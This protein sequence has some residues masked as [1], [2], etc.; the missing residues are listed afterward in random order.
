MASLPSLGRIGSSEDK[1]LARRGGKNKRKSRTRRVNDLHDSR[2]TS[3]NVETGASSSRS[4]ESNTSSSNSGSEDFLV[5]RVGT[6]T[7]KEPETSDFSGNGNVI[8]PSTVAPQKRKS[9]FG[10]GKVSASVGDGIFTES[11]RSSQYLPDFRQV[12][13]SHEDGVGRSTRYKSFIDDKKD[14][15]EAFSMK[16]LRQQ[17]FPGVTPRNYHSV[18]DLT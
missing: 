10:N 14:D 15:K 12:I 11:P 16:N 9:W 4:C 2:T 3:L 18:G 6:P 7:I 5:M 13:P 1:T 8:M 17:Q